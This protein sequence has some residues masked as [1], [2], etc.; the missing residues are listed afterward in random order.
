MFEMRISDF[1]AK[2]R[3]EEDYDDHNVPPWIVL[4][5][6]VSSLPDIFAGEFPGGDGTFV[7]ENGKSWLESHGLAVW[8]TF[9]EV[10]VESGK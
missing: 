6:T 7:T 4:S 9:R 10:V 8:L 1:S 3:Y 5:P 2:A